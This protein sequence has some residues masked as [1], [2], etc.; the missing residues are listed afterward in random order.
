MDFT[1][2]CPNDG[3]V[4]MSLENISALVFSEPESVEIVFE[5][6]HCGAS[7]RASVR[8]PNLLMAAM[9]LARRAEDPDGEGTA[10]LRRRLA[11]AGD[12]VTDSGDALKRARREREGEAYCEYFRRQLA[13]VESLEDFLAEFE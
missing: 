11:E 10:E 6:P 2:I 9:E 5:C 4:E 12:S 13:R 7:L 3:R 8:V 1:L